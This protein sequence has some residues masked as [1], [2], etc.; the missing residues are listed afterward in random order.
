M[1]FFE[2]PDY[3]AAVFSSIEGELAIARGAYERLLE[4]A[5]AEDDVVAISHLM[6]SLANI[7]I[8]D[9]NVELGHELHR[10]AI[11]QCP[12][13]PLN[14][15]VYAKGLAEHFGMPDQAEQRLLEAER[16]LDSDRWNRR[17]DNISR[18]SYEKQISEIRNEITA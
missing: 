16:L 8:R 13:V 11:G 10:R 7:E 15:I 6:Q 9:G 18:E 4:T 1:N 14:L 2:S 12:G 17:I 3:K 5:E